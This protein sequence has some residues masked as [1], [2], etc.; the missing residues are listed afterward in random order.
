MARCYRL[1]GGPGDAGW[2]W[3]P[4]GTAYALPMGAI[5]RYIALGLTVE[6]EQ[7][8]PVALSAGGYEEPASE[9]LQAGGAGGA[10]GRGER[11]RGAGGA[12]VRPRARSRR[13]PAR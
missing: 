7:V 12:G 1:A 11:R 9:L 3:F 6:F 5:G 13:A 8:P 2:G 10:A 4:T